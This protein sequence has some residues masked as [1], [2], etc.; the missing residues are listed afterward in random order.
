MT[1]EA[2]FAKVV[3]LVGGFVGAD[4]EGYTLAVDPFG[5]EA[6]PRGEVRAFYVSPPTTATAAEYLG[7]SGSLISTFS[8]WL[9]R[10]RGDAPMVP[11]KAL[12]ADLG[13]LRKHIEDN[14][15]LDAFIPSGSV[16][17]R[18]GVPEESVVV[19]GELALAVDHDAEA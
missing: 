1:A 9:S 16:T 10:P 8:I 12:L 11:A 17:M 3:E 18:V 4:G 7:S 14:I 5:F 13:A 15:G 19:L 6:D 2:V